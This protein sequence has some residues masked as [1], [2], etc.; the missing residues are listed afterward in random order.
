MFNMAKF[1]FS[2]LEIAEESKCPGHQHHS[3]AW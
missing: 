2:L 3:A 1:L